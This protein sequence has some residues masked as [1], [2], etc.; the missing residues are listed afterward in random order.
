MMV[1]V[2]PSLIWALLIFLSLASVSIFEEGWLQAT[3]TI[4][5]V[6]IAAI[7]SR[8]V[9][10]HYMEAKH[11]AKHWQL[12]YESWNYAAAA[13]IVIGHYMS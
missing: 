2:P 7:K 3:S 11:A 9:I 4:F 6:G 5:I 12:L 1:N 8:F 13:V 10:R